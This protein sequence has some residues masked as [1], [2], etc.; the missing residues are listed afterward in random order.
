MGRPDYPHPSPQGAEKQTGKQLLPP[1]QFRCPGHVLPRLKGAWATGPPS[2]PRAEATVL[3]PHPPPASTKDRRN[4]HGTQHIGKGL[5][6]K[7]GSCQASR[8]AYHRRR[9]AGTPHLLP[10]PWDTLADKQPVFSIGLSVCPSESC[11]GFHT[12][13]TSTSNQ[14]CCGPWERKRTNQFMGHPWGLTSQAPQL[15]QGDLSSPSASS[16]PPCVMPAPGSGALRNRAIL[17]AP[18]PFSPHPPTPWPPGQRLPSQRSQT[19]TSPPLLLVQR[20]ANWTGGRRRK[21]CILGY[22]NRRRP[23]PLLSS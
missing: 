7:T 17:T 1:T 15:L 20:E 13:H 16:K 6:A 5:H 11:L 4:Q 2:F 22:S 18:Q 8:G 23:F 12:Q 14:A 3:S 21:H 10:S 9:P 19:L